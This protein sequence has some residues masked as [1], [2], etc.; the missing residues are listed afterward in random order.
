MHLQLTDSE[1][2]GSI[3]V[4][5]TWHPWSQSDTLFQILKFKGS[6]KLSTAAYT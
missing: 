2:S 5:S 4:I 1:C 3:N 6:V